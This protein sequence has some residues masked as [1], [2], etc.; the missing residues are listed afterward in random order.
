MIAPNGTRLGGRRM[1]DRQLCNADDHRIGE[2]TVLGMPE[3]G[4]A[5]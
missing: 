5:T 1:T 4:S 3:R 2:F